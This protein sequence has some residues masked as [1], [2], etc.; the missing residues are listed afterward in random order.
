[1]YD[2]LDTRVRLIIIDGVKDPLI[3]HLF[4]KNT[5]HDM[6]MALHNLFQNKNENWVLVLEDKLNSTKMIQG[7]G[8]TSYLTRFLQV[9][10]DIFF[11]IVTILD[12]DMVRIYLKGFNKEWKPFIKGIISREKFP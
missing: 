12:S 3:P 11:V 2:D 9:K 5:S 1:M 8:V 4:G 10:Y 6:W 7:E